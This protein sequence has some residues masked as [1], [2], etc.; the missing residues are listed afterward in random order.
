MRS[1]R[2]SGESSIK[3]KLAEA[4]NTPLGRA[5][6]SQQTM[7]LE[8]LYMTLNRLPA[9]LRLHGQFIVGEIGILFNQGQ[10]M[11]LIMIF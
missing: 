6:A 2:S 3:F 7:H 8:F 1:Q 10:Q 9:L 4:P 5:Y 11:T